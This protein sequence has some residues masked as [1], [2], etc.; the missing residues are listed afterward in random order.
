MSTVSADSPTHLSRLRAVSELLGHYRLHVTLLVLASFTAGM[1][2]ATF[3]V[4]ATRT[5]LAIANDAGVVDLTRGITL[6]IEESLLFAGGLIALRML[7]TLLDV[8][9]QTGLAYRVAT[10]LRK[11]MARAFL[12]ASWAIQQAQPAGTL[13]QVVVTFPNRASELLGTL[14]GAGG[15]ALSLSALL[16]MAVFVDAQATLLV[17][18]VLVALSLV[19]GPLRRRIVGR[20][21]TAVQHELVFANKVAEVGALGLEIQAFGT[22]GAV[23]DQLDKAIDQNA[24]SQRSV[25]LLANALSPVYVSLAYAAVILALA[26][27]TSFGTSNLDSVGAVMLVMLRSL[28]YGQMLQ[29]GSSA[30]SQMAPFLEQVRSTLS[31]FAERPPIWGSAVPAAVTPLEF[32]NVAFGYDPQRPVLRDFN[33][34]LEHGEVLG[35]AGAS[36]A[37]KSTFVQLLLGMRCPN[38][39]AIVVAGTPLYDVDRTWWGERVGYVPQEAQLVTGSIAENI[40]FFREGISDAQL[41]QAARAAHIW[42]DICAMPGGLQCHLGERGQQLSGGQRQRLSIARALVGTPDLLVLDE[43][44]SA[45]DVSSEA[46]IRDTLSELKGLVTVVVV[47]HRPTTLE[48]CD[49]TLIISSLDSSSTSTALVT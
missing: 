1:I 27:V 16:A 30:A 28:G 26:A 41:E 36:G 17:L 42:D 11:Q 19:L 48:T 32:Q 14:T 24:L 4:A 43:P 6:T 38:D 21:S 34:R 10:G 7:V 22:Q 2:E 44:T 23:G 20:A 37:G 39:G 45:L 8:R 33:L 9:V 5:G 3:L 49:R 35:V 31:R 40:R 47:A 29:S 13:Q 18:A 46:A 25:R 15:A 12:D